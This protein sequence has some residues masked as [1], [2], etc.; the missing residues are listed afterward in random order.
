MSTDLA[1][2]VMYGPHRA[3]SNLRF[4]STGIDQSPSP[5]LS[6]HGPKCCMKARA[7]FACRDHVISTALLRQ[8]AECAICLVQLAAADSPEGT[9][10]SQVCAFPLHC[11]TQ[12]QAALTAKTFCCN[13]LCPESKGTKVKP[14][15]LQLPL[16]LANLQQQFLLSKFSMYLPNRDPSILFQTNFM[17]LPTQPQCHT[18]IFFLRSEDFDD[19]RFIK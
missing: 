1:M 14:V 18:L 5:S 3:L 4:Y 7:A 10:C 6:C 19:C 12:A 2:R 15:C 17:C 16:I 13:R 11:P 9:S 8:D